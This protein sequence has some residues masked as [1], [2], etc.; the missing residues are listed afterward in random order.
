MRLLAQMLPLLQGLVFLTVLRA[1]VAEGF[2]PGYLRPLEK[3]PFGNGYDLEAQDGDTELSFGY[4][5]RDSWEKTDEMLLR[6]KAE[7]VSVHAG[8]HFRPVDSFLFTLEV[9]SYASTLGAKAHASQ[10]IENDRSS[11]RLLLRAGPLY[12][13][14]GI[15]LGS[16]IKV[17]SISEEDRRFVRD[18]SDV[19]FERKAAAWPTMEG[20]LGLYTQAF[21]LMATLTPT[22]GGRT[23]AK[24]TYAGTAAY[25]YQA[26]FR[27][28]GSLK[29]DYLRKLTNQLRLTFSYA[30][31]ASGAASEDIAEYSMAQTAGSSS[32]FGI[33]RTGERKDKDHSEFSLGASYLPAN[34]IKFSI[35]MHY[36]EPYYS[37][38]EFASVIDDN[39]GGLAFYVGI[40][41]DLGPLATF[42]NMGYRIPSSIDYDYTDQYDHNWMNAGDSVK[43]E[44][45][46]WDALFGFA[47]TL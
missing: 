3:G 22:T 38:D 15:I 25:D 39:L 30:F 4:L 40:H 13:Q 6:T 2:E 47:V 45:S 31:I 29:L 33:A 42:L 8:T 32:T 10:N 7:I 41:Q 26:T 19:R 28:P 20:T 24:K 23:N 12:Q 36:V 17:H 44:Q 43:V 34:Q 5:K 27:E 1:P 35:A 16:R 18:F 14:G 21:S 46:V 9:S 37:K 11:Q